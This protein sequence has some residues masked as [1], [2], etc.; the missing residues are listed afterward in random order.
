M[1]H[2]TEGNT[3]LLQTWECIDKVIPRPK[4]VGFISSAG[5]PITLL[6]KKTLY[7]DHTSNPQ[8]YSP[9]MVPRVILK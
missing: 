7:S 6:Q 9:Q 2:A 4:A 8:L 5:P 1:G 3:T